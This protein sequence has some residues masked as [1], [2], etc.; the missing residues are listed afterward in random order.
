MKR[1][2]LLGAALAG[3]AVAQVVRADSI[4]IDFG[5]E[6][7]HPQGVVSALYS[8]TAAAPDAGT[9]WNELKVVDNNAFQGPPGEF[10]F[11]TSDVTVSN[12]VNSQGVATSI[13]VTAF[14]APPE[15][16][17][18]FAILQTAPNLGA[19]ATDAVDL[20]RDYLIGFGDARIVELSGFAPGAAVD[21]YLYGAGDTDNRDT[22][23]SVTDSA[24]THSATTTGTITGDGNNPQAHTLTLGGD[25]VVLAG[26]LADASGKITISYD[27]GAGSGEAPFNG[28]QAVYVVPE[29]STLLASALGLGAFARRRR[30]W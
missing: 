29:P 6:G 7:S 24:G 21:L 23:F 1:M 17:G 20:M 8:G 9:T 11:W 26:V 15:G 3:I 5:Q 22:A 10:G 4:N 14:A 19:V 18:A 13:S 25:Y 2:H 28:L 12:L 16:T 27:N 30:A